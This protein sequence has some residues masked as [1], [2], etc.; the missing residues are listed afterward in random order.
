MPQLDLGILFLEL[1]LNF[2]FFW[3]IYIYYARYIFP[4]IN[5][6]IKLRKY[7]L[8]S[9]IKRLLLLESN[10]LFIIKL[11]L[12]ILLN[13]NFLLN[14]FVVLLKSKIN[15]IKIIIFSKLYILGLNFLKKESLLNKKYFIIKTIYK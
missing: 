11:N 8:K 6:T 5:K 2:I 13:N 14:K 15:N 3:L 9:I 12:S 1:V 7:K 4:L 10:I